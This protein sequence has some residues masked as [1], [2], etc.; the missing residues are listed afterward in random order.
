MVSKFVYYLSLKIVKFTCILQGS[1][2]D[3][4]N[5]CNFC[6]VKH[7]QYWPRLTFCAIFRI[8]LLRFWVLSQTDTIIIRV[9]DYGH[10]E[11]AFFRK[12]QTFGL[13]QTNWADKFWGIW[14]I[15]GQTISTHFSTV[16]PLYMFSIIQPLFLHKTKPL[17][18][19]GIGVWIWATN[20]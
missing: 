16:S 13:G 6:L 17:Y 4:R 12:S 18:L 11:R 10:P 3:T 9:T 2:W 14:G 5:S 1:K 8:R 15:S 20:N 19:F 7:L